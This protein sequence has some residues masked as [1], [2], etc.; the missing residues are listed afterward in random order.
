MTRLLGTSFAAVTLNSRVEQAIR[1][2]DPKLADGFIVM[3]A[4]F[5]G[6][7][8]DFVRLVVPELQRRG[9]F[10]NDYSGRTLLDHLGLHRH[11][12]SS[13]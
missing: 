7:F 3:P 9:L 12:L 11:L 6:A 4:F 8:D 13:V 5:S 10:R 2:R 1:M